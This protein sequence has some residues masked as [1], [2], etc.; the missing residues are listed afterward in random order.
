MPRSYRF[1]AVAPWRALTDVTVTV[2]VLFMATKSR[3]AC[4]VHIL[5]FIAYVGGEGTN[6]GR[7]RP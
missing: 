2:M 5:C 7:D 4:A 6:I 1:A 3:M